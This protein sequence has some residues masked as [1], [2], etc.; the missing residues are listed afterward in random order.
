VCGGCD[1]G[2]AAPPVGPRAALRRRTRGGRR[3]RVVGTST[4][5]ADA[6]HARVA[7]THPSGHHSTAGSVLLTEAQGTAGLPVPLR[8]A[9]PS[10]HVSPEGVHL[11]EARCMSLPLQRPWWPSTYGRRCPA[12]A[13]RHGALSHF[14]IMVPRW[15]AVTSVCVPSPRRTLAVYRPRGRRDPR[16]QAAAARRRHTRSRARGKPTHDTQDRRVL[17]ART[18]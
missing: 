4:V 13:R 18:L 7:E 6:A 11:A 2:H 10:R 1:T 5:T 9:G 17:R 8:H 3:P 15:G 14:S 16:R 12:L